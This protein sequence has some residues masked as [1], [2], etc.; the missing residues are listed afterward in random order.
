[1]TQSARGRPRWRTRSVDRGEIRRSPAA[2]QHRQGEGLPP[3]RRGQR[4]AAVGNHLLRR[5]GRP[6]QHLRQRRHRG[7]RLG[8]EIP[9]RRRQAD[10]PDGGRRRG[11]RARPHAG[12]ARQDQRPGPHVPARDGHRAAAHARGRGRDRA[13]HRARQA[14]GHQVDLAH[15]ADRQEGHRP[16]RSAAHRRAHH[17]RAGDLQRRGDHRRAHRGAL[18]AG[19]EADRRRPQGARASPRSSKRS[20]ARRPKGATTRDKRKY[21]KCRWAAMRAR[22][23]AVAATSA[24]S[25]SPSR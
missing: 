24:R 3:L 13:P 14:R 15:A 23:R 18:Q 4:A 17:P 11:A 20:C 6:L 2:D 9:A 5:A 25:S 16:R 7:H 12:R 10:R 19:A 21:R 22:D 8:P 1:M